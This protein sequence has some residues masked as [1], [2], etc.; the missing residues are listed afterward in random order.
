MCPYAGQGYQILVNVSKLPSGHLDGRGRKMYMKRTKKLHSIGL[1]TLL[2]LSSLFSFFQQGAVVSA[3]GEKLKKDP[4][5]GTLDPLVTITNPDEGDNFGWN[6]SWIGDVNGDGYDDVIVG[7]PYADGY[8]GVGGWWNNS[9]AYRKKLTF[10]NTGQSEDLVNFP[11]MINLSTMNFNYSKSKS[12]GTDLRFIDADGFSELK[13][14]IEDWESSGSSYIWVNVANIHGGSDS[15]YI[16]MYYGNLDAVDVQDVEGTYD[17]HFSGVWH[18]NETSGTH[19][20]ASKNNNDGFPQNGLTQNAQGRIGGADNFDGVDDYVN[21]K[22]SDSLNITQAITI[23][24]W[25]KPVNIDN[26]GDDL[27]IVNKFADSARSYIL[28]M[29]DDPG[30]LDD[31]DFKLSDNGTA[32][33]GNIH[34]SNV[35]DKNQWQYMAGTWNGTTMVL[36][37]NAIVIGTNDTFS[38]PIYQSATEVWIGDGTYYDA[39]EGIIDEVRI[40]NTGRSA[41]WVMAQYLSMNNS[42][43]TYGSEEESDWWDINWSC[44]MK[45]TFDNG[46]QSEDLEYF[47]VSVKL[48]PANFNYSKAKLDG[49]DLRFVDTDN[50]TELNYHIEEW[51]TSGDSYVWVNVTNIAGDTSTDYIWMYYNNSAALDVQN[52][53]ETYDASYVLVQHLEETS[54]T[55]YDSTQYDNDGTEY[56]D[57]PGTQDATGKIDGADELDGID[58]YIDCGND[59]SL[60]IT[61]TEITM[62]AW[63]YGNFPTQIKRYNVINKY[64]RLTGGY[65]LIVYRHTNNIGTASAYLR[66]SSTYNES[67]CSN[68]YVINPNTWHHVVFT[69]DSPNGSMYVDGVKRADC[70]FGGSINPNPSK[71]L[72]IGRPG[73]ASGG[74]VYWNGTIDEVRISNIA[75]SEDWIYAQ[76]LSMNDSFITYSGEEVIDSGAGAI[77]KAGAAYIFFGYPEIN[78]SALD[79]TDANVTIYGSN[80][81]DLFGWSVSDAGDINN[82]DYDDVIIGAPGWGADRGRAYIFHGRSTEDWNSV[83]DADADADVILTGENDGD[84]FGFSVS[85]IKGVN[86]PDIN[87]E[88]WLYRKKITINASQVAGDLVNFPVL[89]NTV[90]SDL[91]SK[92][93]ADGYDIFFTEMDGSTRLDHELEKYSSSQGELVAW[94]KIPS[95]SSSS[96]TSIYMYYGNNGQTT[97]MENPADVWDSNYSAVWHLSDDFYDSTSNNHDGTNLGSDDNNSIIADG[98]DFEY[99]DGTDHIDVGNWNVQGQGLTL[100]AWVMFESFIA[101]DARIISKAKNDA[102]QDHAWMLST[103]WNITGYKLRFRLKTGTNDDSGTTTYMETNSSLTT[104]KWLFVVATYDGSYM[105]LRLDQTEM[106]NT[107]KTGKIRENDWD[108]YLGLN[109]GSLWKPLDG[110]L[111]EVRISSVARSNAWLDTEYNNQN[112]I[113]SFYMVGLEEINP[114]GW[115]YRK[116]ITINAAQ[117]A[118]DLKDFP[119]LIN[120]TDSDLISKARSDG[121]DI[122][123]T[124]AD[125]V[126]KLDHE[127]ESYNGSMGELVAWVKIPLLSSSSNTVFYMHYSNLDAPE[128]SNPRGV[129]DDNYVMV[130]HLQEKS[131]TH[132]D[133]T[134]YN[135]DGIEYIDSPGTQ[136]AVGKIDGADEFDGSDDYVKINSIGTTLNSK[137]NLT[138]SLWVNTASDGTTWDNPFSFGN[139]NFR[140][141]S[142]DPITNLH[143]FNSGIDNDEIVEALGSITLDAWSYIT[144]A[145]NDSSWVLFVDGAVKDSGTTDGGLNAGSDLFLGVRFEISDQWKGSIDE[146]RISNIT[147]SLDWITTSYKN[148]N[149]SSSF[150]TIGDEEIIPTNWQYRKS[151]II[152]SSQVTGDLTDFPIL[153]DITDSDLKNKARTDGYDIIFT[154]SDGKTR[155]D[156]EIEKHDGTTGELTAWVRIPELS[157]T[158]DTI[159]YLHYGNRGQSSST[160]NPTGVWDDN[161]VMVQHL[162]ESPDDDVEGH[163]DSTINHNEGTPKNFQDSGDGTTDATGRID[164]ADEFGGDDDYVDCG[165]DTSLNIGNAVG[166]SLNAWIYPKELDDSQFWDNILYSKVQDDNNRFYFRLRDEDAMQFYSVIGGSIYRASGSLDNGIDFT[167]DSWYMISWIIDR[168]E[169]A[170][171]TLRVYH[172]GDL[173]G[174]FS[175]NDSISGVDFSNTGNGWIGA[176]NESGSGQ[177]KWLFNGT[178]DEVRISSVARSSH[179]VATEYN[180]QN[181]TGTFYT[182]GAEESFPQNWMYRKAITLNTSKITGDLTDFPIL[183]N[184]VDLDLKNRARPDG[185]DIVFTEQD[186]RTRLDHEIESYNASSG[187]LAA[188]VRIPFL[189]SSSTTTIY[190]HYGNSAQ[191][192]P[193][194]NIEGVWDDSY[195]MV[196]HLHETSGIHYD[197]T[198][199]LNNGIEYIDSPGTQNASGKIDGADE[200]DG[201]DDHVDVAYSSNLD[202]TE[203]ITVEGWFNCNEDHT[204]EPNQWFGGNQ[205]PGAWLLGW[206]GWDDAWCFGIYNDT[207]D[208]TGGTHASDVY[209]T[210]D[211]WVHVL[212]TFDGRYLRV[213][214]NG[215]LEDIEEVGSTTIYSNTNEIK[216][217]MSGAYFNGSIDEVRISN[218]VRSIDWI[219]TQYNN[220]N[221]T[222]TFYSIGSEELNPACWLYRKPITISSSQVA[223]NLTDFPFLIRITD[224]DLKS[225]ALPNGNDILF[226]ELDGRTKLDHEIESYNS[227]SGK[228][229]AWVRIPYLSSSFDTVVYMY[230]GNN[231]QRSP[232]ENPESVWD[233]NYKMVHHLEESPND[234]VE[235]H[236]DSTS[237]DNDGTPKNFQDGG[238]GTTDATGRI[239]GADEFGGD[240]DYIE[241]SSMAMDGSRTFMAWIKPDFN[242]DDGVLHTVIEWYNGVSRKFFIAKHSNNNMYVVHDSQD[243]G[244]AYLCE[245]ETITFS[246]GEWHHIAGTYDDNAK[247]VCIYWDGECLNSTILLGAVELTGQTSVTIGNGSWGEFDGIIDEVRISN[248]AR[249]WDWIDA[250]YNNQND[251][252]SSYTLGNEESFNVN[253]YDNVIVGA[254]GYNGKQGR[255]Y[256]FSGRSGLTGGIS[257]QNADV[258]MIGSHSDDRFGWAVSDAGDLNGD[259]STDIIIGAPGNNSSTG[260]AYVFLNIEY[261]PSSINASDADTMLIGESPNDEFGYSVSNAGDLNNDRYND[262]IV[263]APEYNDN[264]GNYSAAWG[265]LDI[266]ANQN[267]DSAYQNATFIAADYHGNVIVVWHD[268]RNGSDDYDIY[269]QKFDSDGNALW[270]PTDIRVNK[271]SDSV[272]QLD[273]VVVV[274][275]LGNAIIVWEDKRNGESDIYAQKL[276]PNGL[277]L[278][279]LS[280]KKVNQNSDIADQY[281]PDATIDSDDNVI[282]AFGDWRGSDGDLYAQ[283]LDSD[284]A[285]QWG[286]NDK[287]INQNSDSYDQF[288]VSAAVYPN[289]SSIYV[290]FDERNSPGDIADIYAQQLDP[291]G[292]AIWG[293]TDILVNQN[294]DSAVQY[295]PE[296]ATDSDG[297]AYVIWEDARNGAGDYDTFAQRLDS[298]GTALWGPSDKD[299]KQNSDTYHQLD[300]WVDVDPEGNPIFVWSDY[301]NGLGDIYSQKY[302]SSGT[303]QWDSSDIKVN[304]GGASSNQIMPRLDVDSDGHMYVGW[305]DDRNGASDIDIYIQKLEPPTVGRAYIFNGGSSMDATSDLKLTGENHGDRFGFSVKSAGDLNGDAVADV[306]VGA[307]YYDD[308]AKLDVGAIYV[309]SGGSSMDNLADWKYYGEYA[310]DHF[311]WSVS[312]AGDVNGDDQDDIIVGAPANDDGG[313]DAGKTYI[314]TFTI[315]IPFEITDILTTPE[316]Q[317]IDE[318]VNISCNVTAPSGIYGVWLNIT[319]PDGGYTNASMT[320][321]AGNQ[322]YN[323]S[324]YVIPGL[325]QYLIWAN[326]TIGNWTNTAIY[327]FVIV[328]RLPTLS[329]SSVDPVIGYTDTGFNFTVIYTDLDDHAPYNVMVNISGEG[330]YDLSELDPLDLDYTDGKEYYYNTSGFSIGTYSF[331]FAANDTIGDWVEGGTLFFDVL[332]STPLLSSDS[333]NPSSGYPNTGFNFTVKYTSPNNLEPDNILVNITGWGN[334]DLIPIDPLDM[335]YTDGNGFYLNQSGFTLGTHFF[336][337]AANDTNGIWVETGSSSFDILSS[338]LSLTLPSVNPLIGNVDT[339]FN[340]TVNYA[341]PAN[342][343]PVNITVVISSFGTFDLMEVDPFDSDYTDGKEYYF[344]TSGFTIRTYQFYFETNDSIGNSVVSETNQ[345]NILNRPPTFTS[346]QVAPNSGNINSGFN[347]SI[348]YQDLDDQAPNKITVN[349]T[350]YGVYD[351]GEVDSLDTDYTDGKE[352]YYN[353]SGF[354]IGS[355]TFNFAANDTKGDWVETGLLGFNVL[356]RPPSLSVPLVTPT[357]GYLDSDFNFTV[358][359]TDLDDHTPGRITVNISGIGIYILEETDFLD[360][361]YTDGKGYY[362]NMSGFSLGTH[363]FNFAANDSLGNWTES[364]ILQFD[365]INRAPILSAA[366]VDQNTGYI[367]SWFNFT[368]TYSDFDNHSQDTITVNI[369]GVGIYDL[370]EMDLLDVEY[371]DGKEYY[372]NLSGFDVGQYTFSFT[373]ND[374]VGQWTETGVMQFDVVNRAPILSLAQVDPTTGSIDTIFNFTVTYTD[375]EDH[376]PDAIIL[377]ITGL[378]VFHMMEA[379]TSDSDYTDGKEYYYNM[380]LSA[381][382]YSFHYASNDS[383]GLWAPD[384]ST[385]NSPNVSPKHGILYAIDSL[386]EF[387]D[388]IQLNSRLLDDDFQPIQGQNVAYYIDINKNGILEAGEFVDQGVTQSDGSISVI[389]S[390]YLDIG[391]YNFT[392]LYVGSGDY[393]IEDDEAQI[394]INPKQATLKSVITVVEVGETASI[395]AT[396]I[397]DMGNPIGDQQV[398]FYLDRNRNEFYEPSE[399]I[400]MAATSLGGVAQ[401]NYYV[402]LT[403]ENYGI[404][405]KY[406]GSANYNVDEIEGLLTVQDTGNRPPMIV[407]EVPNQIKPED[408]LPWSIA[409]TSYGSDIEDSDTDLNWH[410]TGVDNDLYSVTGMNSTNNI[411]TFIPHPDAYGNDEVTLWLV[412]SSGD[413]DSQIL[414]INIT[415]LNDL[416]YFNPM[417]PDIFV[418]YDDPNTDEDNPSPWDYTFYVHDVETPIENLILTTSESTSD[419]GD[420][421]VEV[422]GL[423]VTFHYPQNMVGQSVLVTLT[424]S[425]GTDTTQTMVRVNVTSDWVPELVSQL[426]DVILEENTTLYYVFDLDDYFVDKDHDSLFFTSGYFHIIVDINQ[427]NTVDITA[428]GQWTGTE[429]VTF[430]A[431]DPIGAI[432]EDTIRVTVIPVNDGPTISDIPDLVVHFDYS[433]AFDL[434]PYISDPDNTPD[435][436]MVSTSELTDYIRLQQNN[437]LGIVITY[438]EWMNST[439]IPITIYVSDGLLTASQ[440]INITISDDFPPE[441]RYKIPDVFFD[442]D[443]NLNGT[444]TLSDYFFDVDN[445]VLYYTNGSKFINVTINK[446]LTVDFSAPENWYGSEVIT[447]RATDPHGALAEDSILVVVVPVNDPPTIGLIP[448]QEKKV[449]DQWILDLSQYIHDIDNDMS[450]LIITVESAAGEGYVTLVGNMLVFQYPEGIKI[451]TITITVTDGELVATS[452]FIVDIKSTKPQAPSIWDTLP[453]PWIFSILI[454]AIGGAIAIYWK[455]SGYIVYDAFLIHENGLPIAH[456]SRWERSDLEDVVV[457][458]MFTAVQDF[459]NDAFSGQ[460]SDVDWELDEMG[461]GENKI[462]IE[463]SECLYIAVIFE[464]YGRKL[465][466]RVRRFFQDI[467]KEYGTILEDWDG[468]ISQLEGIRALTMTLIPDRGYKHTDSQDMPDQPRLDAHAEESD[469]SLYEWK[470]G[471]DE[472]FEDGSEVYSENIIEIEV[473]ECPVC[474]KDID[475]EAA[476]CPRCGVQFAE[477]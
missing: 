179:W 66:N 452:S 445:D 5:E 181:D 224:S 71:N 369:T 401:I 69:W 421:Y 232:T 97:S 87:I 295:S 67:L 241:T 91:Q 394:T 351:L 225:K 265:P 108:I 382:N 387:S 419:S 28:S 300:P 277:P 262:V 440:E 377:N 109:P 114:T 249:S 467:N 420:G 202:I 392:V 38:G 310:N 176:F 203:V 117:V 192:S 119:V 451:D 318:Y 302:N 76:Y 64:N 85:S 184:T 346:P 210:A 115:Q 373:A 326:D 134:Q 404:W 334:Y 359:Y 139:G 313:I 45:L 8:Q 164:G 462:L 448:T 80:S 58:D 301:R 256:I 332:D 353:A 127:I 100:Q 135:Y 365:V 370:I 217:G 136:D 84:R 165:D 338:A 68:T 477:L 308:G 305:G 258:I 271:N 293:N 253:N 432:S 439:T 427:N 471:E 29:D 95:L 11:V 358:I 142:G 423:K 312:F 47:P 25:V 244:G 34:D 242:W 154:E 309:F 74:D 396:L 39:F 306:M 171:G 228:L 214:V 472:A 349:I 379:N 296:V 386:V 390:S 194:E 247:R 153:I 155:L 178:I 476:S 325:Y 220:Q 99:D 44:R 456:V 433:Y 200:F 473:Y 257:A 397:D 403:P 294:S 50:V 188:W 204:E 380:T 65:G 16:W 333:V 129:W 245:I 9:W 189:S 430:R 61:G 140:F 96:D 131:G 51:N 32:T 116:R 414:W 246:S 186:G 195:V 183:V 219:A 101:H 73:G 378:G 37:K 110:I 285:P 62:E 235:G 49:T 263:G 78:A 463:R 54:G 27:N 266:Q 343:P 211:E 350:G 434:S 345:F 118:G 413:R 182:V 474:G 441:L 168:T 281:N 307:P 133:S 104:D 169:G 106:G 407:W 229:V 193:T 317:Y 98:Q 148:Q 355:F 321:G 366:M 458:G 283:K 475:A 367:E 156:H 112:G 2:V 278:W 426:P 428:Q 275:S 170:N 175:F 40:S 150:Y 83:Y 35:V 454:A 161:Y 422:D 105:R 286:L 102:E 41:D 344:N 340:F 273:P 360:T 234:D 172:N 209:I 435:E 230:Y 252:S 177:A 408:S 26:P 443:T 77:N 94:I 418:H 287:L 243:D 122:V 19:Y 465:R 7:A 248:V 216:I 233:D 272:D 406:E 3:E 316:S 368:V 143:V 151:I 330:V 282:V 410:L 254:Y 72:W 124:G 82:D 342:L 324:M 147:R 323:N 468:D 1:I 450:E 315:S 138:F 341:S 149:D 222:G 59:A 292:N 17:E 103:I 250:S 213:Y 303:A 126:T 314:L 239:D 212:G 10:D 20:D 398:V 198:K 415:P 362:Y 157:S 466:K 354:T 255:A 226:T 158:L 208:W 128:Q 206:N 460:T 453:W 152:N 364:T 259:G 331:H 160:E 409:L 111:D 297:N 361:D 455:K 197:S 23:E 352:Y 236:I 320:E 347:F 56:I 372:I 30:D 289:G 298:M 137:K 469:E 393:D 319:Y 270:G 141:E 449:G 145:S 405:A 357:L 411:L 173:A 269:A 86:A 288:S 227:S 237:N 416:P 261:L 375:L 79:I 113:N 120:L 18:L 290:W 388:A 15:D 251:P 132:Y 167:K 22:T 55:H 13:F 123:F 185:Y 223:G 444:F 36:Y 436:L 191:T 424:L 374:S 391:I 268:T 327:Q 218:V 89:I 400:V 284:G 276:D 12:D 395:N 328:N 457:S 267:P 291:D 335:D 464:G 412:D 215:E 376:P 322:W 381:A 311:G 130:Q 205:K 417:P 163:Y 90:D 337:F 162:E 264:H 33:Q 199:Y 24:A 43:I 46:G 144:F 93:R 221:D 339:G 240:D 121:Y 348:I 425:D 196:Q 53:N 336:H 166:F 174:N 442:E 437:N 329:S 146:V 63:I 31:W 201:S 383:M 389:Y 279:G 459:I 470:D 274:D 280:D 75:R 461:F 107:T 48:N 180:N 88:D 431:Q 52:E 60:N 429:Y 446:D 14:H 399:E 187:E 238:D 356:N 304:E 21:C 57:S 42:F 6:V 402:N 125:G 438:P 190:M 81:G 4:G 371:T 299:A 384:T 231:A 70:D 159:I 92:A 447:F 385:I 363:F 260:A 207:G